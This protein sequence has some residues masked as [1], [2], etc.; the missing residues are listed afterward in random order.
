MAGT[1]KIDRMQA[2]M[3]FDPEYMILVIDRNVTRDLDEGTGTV[4]ISGFVS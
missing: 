4:A 3:N 1:I 2:A